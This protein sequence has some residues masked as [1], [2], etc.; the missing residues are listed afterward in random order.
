MS[1]IRQTFIDMWKPWLIEDKIFRLVQCTC[2]IWKSPYL[3]WNGLAESKDPLTGYVYYTVKSKIFTSTHP[4]YHESTYTPRVEQCLSPRPNRD[5][6]TPSPAS[7]CSPPP[8][9]KGGRGGLRMGGGEV[10]PISVS[11]PW[12]FSTDPDRGIFVSDLQDDRK[13]FSK[14]FF[15][16]YFWKLHLYYFLK[17]KSHKEVTKPKELRFFLLFF[18]DYRRIRVPRTNG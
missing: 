15:A 13:K 8:G 17:I 9:T 3:S 6:P 4:F 10:V 5:P 14:L 11:D 7:E 2:I 18:L 16:F 12:H 1:H